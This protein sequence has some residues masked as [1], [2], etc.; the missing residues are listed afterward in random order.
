MPISLRT[1]FAACNAVAAA[2]SVKARTVGT[3]KQARERVSSTT[4]F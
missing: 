4:Y 2:S 1:R 3:A